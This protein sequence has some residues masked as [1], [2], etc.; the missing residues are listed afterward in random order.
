M[1]RSLACG[2]VAAALLTPTIAF[3]ATPL[4]Y[5]ETLGNLV[6]TGCDAQWNGAC[7]S[8]WHGWGDDDS[9]EM[10]QATSNSSLHGIQIKPGSSFWNGVVRDFQVTG[11]KV[12][13][14]TVPV[15]P[16]EGTVDVGIK[17]EFKNSSGTIVSTQNQVETVTVLGTVTAYFKAPATA[18]T[19]VVYTGA[20]NGSNSNTTL[21]IANGMG[22]AWPGDEIIDFIDCEDCPECDISCPSG[23]VVNYC[24][25][26]DQCKLITHTCDCE[27]NN[28]GLGTGLQTDAAWN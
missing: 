20:K 9:L 6:T 26:N 2:L 8:G 3:A 28:E 21:V 17:V 4:P 24:T 18:T 25:W 13:Q 22:C 14:W 19:A 11:G 10:V 27:N 12:L 23:E 1:A 5:S 7:E 15:I 16:V